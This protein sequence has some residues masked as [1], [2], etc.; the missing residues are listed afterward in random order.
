MI[1]G[2]VALGVL[3]IMIRKF[4]PLYWGLPPNQ[5]RWIRN[6][7]VLNSTGLVSGVFRELQY[8]LRRLVNLLLTLLA[9][10]LVDLKRPLD[11]GDSSIT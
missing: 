9:P 8:S 11:N 2:P 5:M 6:G 3:T 10:A 4:Y 7:K 1:I